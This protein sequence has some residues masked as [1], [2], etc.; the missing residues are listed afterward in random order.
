MKN[1]IL[2]FACVILFY[3]GTSAQSSSAISK[4]IKANTV[5]TRLS[6]N[7]GALNTG[8]MI[9]WP[10]SSTP[11]EVIGDTYWDAHW[12]NTTVLMYENEK[13]V[14]GYLTRLDIQKSELEF[15]FDKQ[16]KV[17]PGNMIKNVVWIDSVT[18]FPRYLVNAQD[19]TV[20]NVPLVGFLEVLS[21]GSTTLFKRIQLEILKPN[22]SPAHDVGR[23]DYKIIKRESFYFNVNSELYKIK[24]K[25]SV[26]QLFTGKEKEMEAFLK[27]EDIN[28]NKERDL[29]KLFTH[30]KGLP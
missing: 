8:E 14:E 28:F 11:A 10:Q 19:Y 2:I 18:K 7:P 1:L 27:Q 3:T 20:E 5:L 4:T 29:V 21:D 26:Q 22:Y 25:K 9:A 13:L 24:S 12:G 17:L 15:K 30:L 16:I 6:T 23:K